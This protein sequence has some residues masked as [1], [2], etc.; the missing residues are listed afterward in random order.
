MKD[1]PLLTQSGL[2]NIINPAGHTIG[3]FCAHDL[4]VLKVNRAFTNHDSGT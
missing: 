1:D 3:M 4:P 2:G